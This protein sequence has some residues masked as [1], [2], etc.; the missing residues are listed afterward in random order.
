M[1][2][3]KFIIIYSLLIIISVII[4]VLFSY[5]YSFYKEPIAKIIEEKSIY[6]STEE[7]TYGYKEKVYIQNIKAKILNGTYKGKI[8][9]IENEYH[10]GEA[11]DMK[12]R[13]NDEVFLDLNIRNKK[14]INARITEYKRDKYVILLILL[15]ILVIVLVG[16]I[17]GFL[18]IIS[19]FI[20]IV[21][22]YLMIKISSKGIS[23]P[24]LSYIS[25]II[26]SSICLFLVSGKNRKTKAAIIS[27]ITGVT[28]TMLLVLIVILFTKY[29]GIRFE[30]ME[31]LT[32]PAEDIFISEVILGG[33]GA[34]MDISITMSSS[35]N[36]LI[37]KNKRIS[38]KKL[39]N[40]G[41]NIGKD[42]MSTMINVLFFTYISS[43]IINL[44]IYFRNGIE[45][46]SLLTEFISLEMTRAL[47]GAIGIVITIPIAIK[48][49]L[50]VFKRRKS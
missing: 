31:L 41:I 8:V 35:L 4:Y 28:V 19:V 50:L 27:S 44:S 7:I 17:K 32:R 39:Y 38:Y 49:S 21:I 47:I 34:I 42:V 33:L 14:I 48:I 37:E 10:S 25:S 18:S 22:F 2:N 12:Y 24:L 5:N 13:I 1:N 3:K 40:S 16:K 43:S 30:Q 23:L 15:I 46:N 20:N 11:Y 6:Q 36:E 9:Y 45:V 29:D 26:F